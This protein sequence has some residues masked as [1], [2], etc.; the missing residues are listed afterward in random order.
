MMRR[1]GVLAR[2]PEFLLVDER[3]VPHAID[4]IRLTAWPDEEEM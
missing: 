2:E 4:E 1:L 3:G